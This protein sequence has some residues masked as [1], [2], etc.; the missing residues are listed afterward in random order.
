MTQSGNDFT[1][2]ADILTY[3]E[4]LAPFVEHFLQHPIDVRIEERGIYPN[5]SS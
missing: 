4:I 1:D 3:Q 5:L 2:V